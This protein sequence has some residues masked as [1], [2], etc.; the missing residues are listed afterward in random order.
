LRTTRLLVPWAALLG[1]AVLLAGVEITALLNQWDVMRSW[2][3][4]V[5]AVDGAWLVLGILVVGCAAAVSVQPWQNREMTAGLPDSG[6]RTIAA[7]GVVVGLVAVAVHVVT[8]AA[9]LVW[10][11]AVG[12]PG[13]PRLWP[14]LSVL[15]GLLTCA[16]FGTAVARFGAGV[17][18][19]LLA[20]GAYLA[21]LFVLRAL[22]GNDL[23]DLGGVSVVLVGLA[24]DT[25]AMIW[26][27]AWL[28][29]AGV[30][31]WW[32]AV[33]GRRA[34]CRAR[35]LVLV[36][37]TLAL[38]ITAAQ[39]MDAGF[40]KTPVKWV[41][42]PGPPKVCVA[43]EYDD[44]LVDYA[45]AVTRMAPF[46]EQVGLPRPPD[47]YRQT[48]GVRPGPGSFNVDAQLNNEQLA[49][50]LVQFTLP[51]SVRWAEPQLQQADVVAAWIA[52]QAGG[53]LPP[54]MRIPSVDEA[55]AAVA[56]LRCDR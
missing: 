48:V 50:D 46:A 7:A 9:L 42:E 14:V 45:S 44:R 29:A 54:D 41:C 20:M 2:A 51:C 19:P 40:V 31:A 15:A 53:S 12:L 26:R 21:V 52:T 36:P 23:I 17:L 6:A 8:V 34:F 39:S 22:G 28:V 33:H 38:A 56:S 18:T 10:G 49:F 25:Q 37:V 3:S 11:W 43:A 55:R 35:F 47:G 32:L 5:E 1:M 4:V 13:H 27:A 16:M 24:P 30:I